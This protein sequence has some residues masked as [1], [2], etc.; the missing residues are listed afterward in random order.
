MSA[1]SRLLRIPSRSSWTS[2][3]LLNCQCDNFSLKRWFLVILCIM[4]YYTYF[5]TTP[6]E[7]LKLNYTCA[8]LKKKYRQFN[9]QLAK[10]AYYFLYVTS[11]VCE[12]LC[13]ESV[14]VLLHLQ[15][16]HF[17][18]SVVQLQLQE[19]FCYFVLILIHS[20]NL[21]LTS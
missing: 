9:V 8:F 7:Q 20:F 13:K 19:T 12:S 5:S 21:A 16:M 11:R 15:N 18:D 10:V 6:L 1:S 3:W 17:P 4:T 2:S 14:I